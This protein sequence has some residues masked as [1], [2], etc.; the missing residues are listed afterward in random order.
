[1][2]LLLTL[3]PLWMPPDNLQHGYL[4]KHAAVQ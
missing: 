3:L 2:V 1:M 4:S